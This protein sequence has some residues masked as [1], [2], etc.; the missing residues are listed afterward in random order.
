MTNDLLATSNALADVAEQAAASVLQVHVHRR[1][2][3]GVVHSTGRVLTMVSV[4]GSDD[5]L[6]VRRLDGEKLP[7]RLVGWDPTSG[8][9]LLNVEGLEAP[10]V[11]VAATAPR[12]GNVATHEREGHGWVFDHA[13][14]D[15]PTDQLVLLAIANRVSL[16]VTESCLPCR[17]V[18]RSV[19]YIV[20]V[21]YIQSRSSTRR[22][23][24][25]APSATATVGERRIGLAS[26]SADR[27][28]RGTVQ[29]GPRDV[30]ADRWVARRG[31]LQGPRGAAFPSRQSSPLW[32][33]S[34]QIRTA[35]GGVKA[36]E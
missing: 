27:R 14:T 34:S 10:P 24:G 12:V 22:R 15:N 30:A 36:T 35:I 6:H 32:I 13:P 18:T 3:S 26:A 25:L 8:L 17:R 7:A 33:G 21:R 4:L 29:D 20:Y 23:R 2:A 31:N 1:P 28:L 16:P 9:A 5:A 11:P 19:Q